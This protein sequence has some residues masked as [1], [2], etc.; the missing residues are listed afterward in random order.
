MDIEATCKRILQLD[1][2]ATPGP[3][4]IDP[5]ASLFDDPRFALRAGP[6]G[7]MSW[8]VASEL[9]ESDARLFDCPLSYQWTVV[10]APPG[11]AGAF[12]DASDPNPTFVGQAPGDYL[13]KV[14]VFDCFG[15]GL[16]A[17][18][19]IRSRGLVKSAG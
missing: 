17:S 3:F 15:A 6:D 4:D 8:I 7:I 5:V 13:L 12:S 16:M 10:S 11:G 2:E 9:T 1:A 18:E 14:T 19:G